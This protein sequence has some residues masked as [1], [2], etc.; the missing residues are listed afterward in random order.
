MAGNSP[1]L[2]GITLDLAE[3][4]RRTLVQV[5][6]GVVALTFGA[7]IWLSGDSVKVGWLRFYSAAVLLGL[8]V[9]WFWDRWIWSLKLVQRFGIAPRDIRGTW[10]GVVESL[11]VNPATN[12]PPPPK[13]AYLVVSQTTSHIAVQ[14]FTDES[15]STSSLAVLTDTPA[16]ASLDYMYL[17]KPG[18]KFEHRSRSSRFGVLVRRW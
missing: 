5:V 2:R 11:W 16:G 3:M 7:G 13:P 6:A 18:T 10:K 8:F 4:N 12:E 15:R 14:L 1:R 17:A 9:L